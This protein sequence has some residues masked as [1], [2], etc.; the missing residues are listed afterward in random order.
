MLCLVCIHWLKHI[1][2]HTYALICIHAHAHIGYCVLLDFSKYSFLLGILL[3]LEIALVAVI[4]VDS[5][6]Q[7]VRCLLIFISFVSFFTFSLSKC[8]STHLRNS[9]ALTVNS[10]WY[11]NRIAQYREFLSRESERSQVDFFGY[12]TLAGIKSLSIFGPF[13]YRTKS[14][15]EISLSWHIY[16]HCQVYVYVCTYVQKVFV[17]H[18]CSVT[19]YI[20]S[21]NTADLTKRIKK[22]IAHHG[23]DIP[24]SVPQQ[25]MYIQ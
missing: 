1:H 14:I 20:N 21:V 12:H 24:S 3:V 2:R 17:R 7:N 22:T 19:R 11:N 25:C 4:Y 16:E 9:S 18:L 15:V 6:W 23:K 8:S 5:S 10:R 13:S